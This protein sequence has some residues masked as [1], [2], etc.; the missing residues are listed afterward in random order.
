MDGESISVIFDDSTAILSGE[1]AQITEER[2]TVTIDGED[3][4]LIFMKRI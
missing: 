3:T 4:P 2:S 1:V